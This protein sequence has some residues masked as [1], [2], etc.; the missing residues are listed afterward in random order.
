LTAIW[1]PSKG[2]MENYLEKLAEIDGL[3]K[4]SID[5]KTGFNHSRHRFVLPLLLDAQRKGILPQPCNLICFDRHHDCLKPSR[6]DDILSLDINTISLEDFA[7]FCS[8]ILSPKNDDWIIAG[9]ELGLIE[10][11]IVFGIYDIDCAAPERDQYHTSKGDTH[12][13]ILK[14]G[15]LGYMLKYQGDLSDAIREKYLREFW[16]ILGWSFKKGKGYWFNDDRPPFLL[17]IDLD[18][19]SYVWDEFTFPWP[20]EVYN[21]RYLTRSEYAT[22]KWLSGKDVFKEM[23]NRAGMITIATEPGCCG[24]E[25]K[26]EQILNDVNRILLDGQLEY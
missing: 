14:T 24:G 15:H 8:S 22:V 10:D 7:D 13:V 25:E 23:V 21:K 4:I 11:V 9:I 3:S 20:E 18:C 1:N 2:V 26:S 16:D 19:F 12:R 5:D 17:D 6:L